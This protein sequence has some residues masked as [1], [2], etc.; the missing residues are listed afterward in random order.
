MFTMRC[1]STPQQHYTFPLRLVR[2]YTGSDGE[3]DPS[4]D[5]RRPR[6]PARRK[7]TWFSVT[8][9]KWYVRLL[10]KQSGTMDS[11]FDRIGLYLQYEPFVFTGIREFGSSASQ[12]YQPVPNDGMN[13]GRLK[14]NSELDSLDVAS[15]YADFFLAGINTRLPIPCHFC[16]GYYLDRKTASRQHRLIHE[17]RNAGL[18]N[19]VH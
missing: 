16:S 14:S 3:Q 8:H 5:A 12:I 9:A 17:L 7:L 19:V 4:K 6:D 11:I 2:G 10:A 1:Y 13:I 15:G 18:D